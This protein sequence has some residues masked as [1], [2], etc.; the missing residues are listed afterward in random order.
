M[1]RL[2]LF[3][4]ICSQTVL[5]AQ[6]NSPDPDVV[7][8]NEQI[9]YE[10]KENYN[11]VKTVRRRFL[12]LNKNGLSR[13]Q[14]EASYDPFKKITG[15][16]IK[17]TDLLGN[18]LTT[19]EQKTIYDKSDV[20][21]FSVYEDDRVKYTKIS[22]NVYPVVIQYNYT[23]DFKEF[24][25]YIHW[26]AQS[27]PNLKVNKAELVIT[28]PENRNVRFK[29]FNMKKQPEITLE[30]GLN[31]LKFN[32]DSIPAYR[33]EPYRP[34]FWE[35]TPVVF[36]MPVEF[37]YHGY[38]GSFET[39]ESYGEWQSKLNAD[40]DE[41]P[42]ELK[43][44]IKLL[45]A[46]CKDTVEMIKRIYEFMQ[47]NTRYVSIQYG[48]GGLQPESASEVNKT[49]YGDCKALSNYTVAMLEEAGIKANYTLVR[50]G[51]ENIPVMPDFPFNFFNHVIVNVPLEN[52]TIWLECTSQQQAFNY[53]GSFTADRYVLSIDGDQSK[54]IKTPN[55]DSRTNQSVNKVEIKINESGAADVNFVLDASGFK[56]EKYSFL[57]V[58]DKVEQEKWIL[59]NIDIK[60]F[61]LKSFDVSKDYSGLPKM[62]LKMQLSINH[63]AS[64]SGKRMFI[65]L[66][67]YHPLKN[68]P[69]A[70]TNRV[71]DIILKNSYVETDSVLFEIPSG[72]SFEYLPDSTHT[73]TK[74]GTFEMN[75]SRNGNSIVYHRKLQVNKGR[76]P[77]SDYPGFLK[78]Y[79]T[80]Q[81]V[82]K[83]QMVLVKIE[84]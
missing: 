77:A 21:G 35:Q 8:L 24:Y 16:K 46:N 3:L 10:L 74:F 9:K 62:E 41:L 12:V 13:A 58:E 37:K 26:A 57:L 70:D 64:L 18:E 4:L 67:I 56:Y 61:D 51:N 81:K 25:P 1:S 28:Y 48:I 19:K 34:P 52:D 11:A 27:S 50:A 36:A 6:N 20:H 49:G 47:D 60:S 82:D 68:I 84:N 55:Y 75:V 72:Y 59:K 42:D 43:S 80:I 2:F 40:R 73:E 39:W 22:I 31:T 29:M 69:S 53:L 54:L 14:F 15:I 38:A 5:V 78:F 79:K 23:K 44:K 83:Q 66:K 17:V 33:S 32:V 7:L 30:K 76:F 63:Y 65:P 71:N 45:T